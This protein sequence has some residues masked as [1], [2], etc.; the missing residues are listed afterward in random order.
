M[1]RLHD[2]KNFGEKQKV[3]FSPREGE[4]AQRSGEKVFFLE[5]PD[6]DD[7]L[8]AEALDAFYMDAQKI[9]LTIIYIQD[10]TDALD[11]IHAENIHTID[12]E[13]SSRLRKEISQRSAEVTVQ[14]K[15]GKEGLEYL[16]KKTE[17]LKKDPQTIGE[18]SAV[19][20]IHENFYF[21]LA[22]RL[23][24]AMIEYQRRQSIHQ[25][26]YK[27]QTK[28]QI[29]IKYTKADGTSIDDQTAQQLTEQVL[30]NH[31]SD[32]IFQ[33]SKN[34]LASIT[35]TRNDIYRI[36]QSIRDLNQIFNEMAILV[37][38]QGGVMDVIL[39]NLKS[40]SKYLEKGRRELRRGR[41]YQKKSRK[42]LYCLLVCGVILV[43]L[44]AVILFAKLLPK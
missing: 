35:E 26:K 37:N 24:Q 22:R 15:I 6:E 10:I 28:R 39:T 32:E 29:Q 18:N 14:L 20:R 44:I 3:D 30:Q 5:P 4:V 11:E 40:T 9:H 38:E 27:A 1:N 13:K 16:S 12:P 21:Y 33:Q 43:I 8:T 19:I 42:K 17:E 23:N 34:L 36:E 7:L 41:K 31:L 2:F 25:E